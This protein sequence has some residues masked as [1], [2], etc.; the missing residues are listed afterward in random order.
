MKLHLNRD[1]DILLIRGHVAGCITIGEDSYS[2]SLILSP[3]RLITDWQPQTLDE[4]SGSDFEV[5][6]DL[7]PEVVLLGTGQ[8][9]RFPKSVVTLPLLKQSIGIEV[10]D[11]AAACR[12]YNILAGEGRNVVACLILETA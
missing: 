3:N 12:T 10:M 4:L 5:M 8:R 7:A 6:L 9:L 1:D 2:N 11:T